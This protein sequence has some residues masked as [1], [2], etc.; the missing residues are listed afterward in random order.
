M[1]F[2]SPW[3]S[4][5]FLQTC[6]K[7]RVTLHSNDRTWLSS[8]LLWPFENWAIIAETT[9]F[10]IL[11]LSRIAILISVGITCILL[12]QVMQS[13]PTLRIVPSHELPSNLESFTTRKQKNAYAWFYCVLFP[14]SSL[15]LVAYNVVKHMINHQAGW[16]G[17][18]LDY[19]F[20]FSWECHHPNWRT[21]SII[22][23]GW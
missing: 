19:D 10:H 22:F 8:Q 15:S 7:L 4:L 12:G 18:L 1:T 20:P 14:L 21:H 23:R 2:L 3:G 9:G 16:F 13:L 11:R 5:G 6:C 17:T